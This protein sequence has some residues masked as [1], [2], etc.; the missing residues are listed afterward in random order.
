MLRILSSFELQQ[1]FSLRKHGFK[2]EIWEEKE[3][4]F[5]LILFRHPNFKVIF[6]AYIDEGDTL[7]Y[8]LTLP[9]GFK[10]DYKMLWAE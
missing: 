7:L 2:Q 9:K 5:R 10:K 1:E 4:G 6:G 8:I 3:T